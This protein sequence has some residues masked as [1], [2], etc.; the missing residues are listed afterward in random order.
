MGDFGGAEGPNFL[1]TR[2][3]RGRIVTVNVI[4]HKGVMADDAQKRKQK[5]AEEFADRME[6]QMR[7]L[8]ATGDFFCDAQRARWRQHSIRAYL[9]LSPDPEAEGSKTA[10]S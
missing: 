8:G 6:A 2:C 4:V 5:K 10:Q 9:G 7:E 1:A 3:N